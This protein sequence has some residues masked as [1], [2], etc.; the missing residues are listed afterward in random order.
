MDPDGHAILAAEAGKALWL[1]PVDGGTPRRLDVDI[2][3][4]IDG[5]GIR[6]SPDGKQIAYFTGED[7]REVW[8]LE[9][10]VPGTKK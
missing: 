7:A 10:V 1:V 5:Q 9:N 8:A 2:S 4:W 6:L 3:R